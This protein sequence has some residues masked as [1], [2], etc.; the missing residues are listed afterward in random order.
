MGWRHQEVPSV[1]PL[2]KQLSAVTRCLQRPGVCGD[3]VSAVT[4]CLRR[5]GVCSDPVSAVTL[6]LQRPSVR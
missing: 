4:R 2:R 5:P 6:C 3:P 1:L